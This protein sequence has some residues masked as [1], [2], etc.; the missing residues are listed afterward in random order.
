MTIKKNLHI[1]LKIAF[2][3]IFLIF[4][5]NLSANEPVSITYQKFVDQYRISR[6]VKSNYGGELRIWLDGYIAEVKTTYHISPT[7][8]VYIWD[9]N[10]KLADDY[11]LYNLSDYSSLNLNSL[12]LMVKKWQI[13]GEQGPK[14]RA[15]LEAEGAVGVYDNRWVTGKDQVSIYWI[16]LANQ[17]W[18]HIRQIGSSIQKELV[19]GKWLGKQSYFEDPVLGRFSFELISVL[20]EI[21]GSVAA[22]NIVKDLKLIDFQPDINFSGSKLTWAEGA[23]RKRYF[24]WSRDNGFSFDV[25]Q[26]NSVRNSNKLDAPEHLTKYLIPSKSLEFFEA[27]I[28]K[29][30]ANFK[31]DQAKVKS[32]DY[33]SINYWNITAPIRM[34][35]SVVLRPSVRMTAE[36]RVAHYVAYGPFRDYFP[37]LK[38][39]KDNCDDFAKTWALETIEFDL[40][41]IFKSNSGASTTYG[42]YTSPLDA[43]GFAS[44]K[45]AIE[46]GKYYQS[47]F[48]ELALKSCNDYFR[49]K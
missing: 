38:I 33:E 23:D 39:N 22:K 18:L 5:K 37:L 10:G 34:T 8:Q 35:Q 20:D 19:L 41:T 16:K 26:W 13:I 21:V 14:L 7:G 49:S 40:L 31:L 12:S 3:I 29:N 42:Y 25:R 9:G 11:L 4:A 1:N 17:K 6:A 24:F 32:K 43:Y 28:L 44:E 45:M 46:S 27:Q 48:L 15:L 47:K 30:K 36:D 2:C